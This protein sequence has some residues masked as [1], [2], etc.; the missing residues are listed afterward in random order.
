MNMKKIIQLIS[1]II[2]LL[3][4]TSCESDSL[5]VNGLH[6]VVTAPIT[7]IQK[8]GNLITG[9]TYKNLK[10]KTAEH[11]RKHL[12]S[13]QTIIC[14]SDPHNPNPD[15]S[16]IFGLH[17]GLRDATCSCIAWGS[18]TKN[19]CSCEK[20]CPWSF[21]IL[22]KPNMTAINDYSK[23]E[24]SV[25]FRNTRAAFKAGEGFEGY[26][27]GHAAVTQ[28]FNRL[29]FFEP[30]TEA[31]F[32]LEST[33][34][35]EQQQAIDYY[36]DII[37]QIADNKTS[38]IPGFS[39]LKEFASEPA[40]QEYIAK[41]MS[42][43]WANRNTRI[44]S[45]IESAVL[46]GQTETSKRNVVEDVIERLDN[47]QQPMLSIYSPKTSQEDAAYHSLLVTGHGEENGK[48]YLCTRDNNEAPVFNHSCLNK[49]FFDS[50]NN[51]QYTAWGKEI[52][53]IQVDPQENSETVQHVNALK[54]RCEDE[55][56][57]AS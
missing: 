55:K 32:N 13:P 9:N 6:S 49:I 43:A 24:H 16:D 4:L 36:K 45:W 39:N 38:S 37:D 52:T 40:I 47:F 28:K 3:F 1:L 20:L 22:K 31:P 57:C 30:D 27:T 48:K 42:Y 14:S 10:K 18:C 12:D 21:D 41:K 25:P 54:E 34:E 29:G 8:L 19:V 17:E 35:S 44:S 33:D 53:D 2:V 56:D 51:L 46:A 26:C 15:V 11:R 7:G 23:P 5:F 50:D